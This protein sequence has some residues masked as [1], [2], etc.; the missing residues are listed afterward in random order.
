MDEK[1]QWDFMATSPLDSLTN[2][3]DGRSFHGNYR[4]IPEAWQHGL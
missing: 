2:G 3:V 4:L 1:A